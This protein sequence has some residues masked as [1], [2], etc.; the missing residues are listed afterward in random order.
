M[1]RVSLAPR[2]RIRR[3]PEA[4]GLE[5]F[6]SASSKDPMVDCCG[7]C[8]STLTGERSALLQPL[9]PVAETPHRLER[10]QVHQVEF[11][12]LFQDRLLLIRKETE[13]V[14]PAPDIR[15]PP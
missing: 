15:L 10:R 4:Q 11:P 1:F 9:F 12:Q 7:V 3:I 5:S 6:N 8:S 2:K 14:R 13:L